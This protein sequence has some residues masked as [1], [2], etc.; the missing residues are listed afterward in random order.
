MCISIMRVLPLF[1]LVLAAV[2]VTGDSAAAPA[3]Q[4]LFASTAHTATAQAEQRQS[5]LLSR[6]RAHSLAVPQVHA[7]SRHTGRT[8]GSDTQESA[9]AVADALHGFYPPSFRFTLT[10]IGKQF[11]IELHKNEQLVGDDYRHIQSGPQQHSSPPRAPA[12]LNSYRLCTEKHFKCTA[13]YKAACCS[14]EH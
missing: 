3:P 7:A 2:R 12:W 1:V 11:D 8:M 5:H 10:A 14:C 6:L 13:A 9:A 4:P